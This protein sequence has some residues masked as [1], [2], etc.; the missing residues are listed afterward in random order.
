MSIVFSSQLGIC[1]ILFVSVSR[2]ILKSTAISV[3]RSRFLFLDLFEVLESIVI[4]VILLN[5][6]LFCA[7]NH[8]CTPS[9]C[10]FVFAVLHKLEI[11]LSKVY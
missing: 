11:L 6:Y 4:G 2:S 10:V 7:T 9:V 3:S 5:F 8:C 1:E